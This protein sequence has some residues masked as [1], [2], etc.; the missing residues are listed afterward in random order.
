MFPSSHSPHPPHV[1]YTSPNPLGGVVDVEL[2]LGAR[3]LGPSSSNADSVVGILGV[4]LVLS[5]LPLVEYQVYHV[6]EA[7]LDGRGGWP[8]HVVDHRDGGPESI[9]G[10]CG[11]VVE[12]AILPLVRIDYLL[13]HDDAGLVLVDVFVGENEIGA[14]RHAPHAVHEALVQSVGL[15][16]ARERRRVQNRRGLGLDEETGRDATCLHHGTARQAGNME[17]RGQLS[18]GEDN[19]VG[20]HLTYRPE[21]A[22]VMNLERRTPSMVCS[23]GL[24]SQ[25]KTTW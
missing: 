5:A 12:V 23:A 4:P 9:Q 18:S 7:R 11:I 21:D 13:A 15:E 3:P 16:S 10:V 19:C 22:S 8:V 1:S 6:G 2:H 20:L 25:L 17:S 24:L 14:V